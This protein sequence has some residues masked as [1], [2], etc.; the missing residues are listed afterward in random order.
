MTTAQEIMNAGV[1]C[2]QEN[3]TLHDAARMMRDLDVGSLPICGDD[4]KLHGVITDRDIVL[5]CCAEGRNPAE[6]RAGELTGPVYWARSSDDVRTVLDTMEQRQIK[7]LPVIDENRRL[8][9][10]ISEGD[11]ARN[12]TD[13]QISE[14]VHKV[15]AE[16]MRGS[17]PKT[18]AT[19]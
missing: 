1:Q 7:R 12:L 2:V 9:G 6:V 13:E 17:R 16:S 14:F 15:Y 4:D 5:R 11:L 8:V 10:M 3:Q 18:G 19:G